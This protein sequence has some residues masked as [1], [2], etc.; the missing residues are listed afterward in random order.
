MSKIGRNDPCSCGSEKKYKKCCMNKS[1]IT[2]PKSTQRHYWDQDEIELMSNDEIIARLK[3]F[4][5]P[6]DEREF[7]KES[8]H[9]KSA[10]DLGE[11]WITGN[12][13]TAVGM[14]EDFI[15]IACIVLWRR[16]LPDRIC[17]EDID[18]LMQ[19]GYAN[20]ND[21]KYHNG[22]KKWKQVWNSLKAHFT[23]EMKDVKDADIILGG[24]QSISSWCQDYEEEL[25]NAIIRDSKFHHDRLILCEE[26][27][28]F[29]PNSDEKILVTMLV[30]KATSLYGIGE[31]EKGETEFQNLIKNHPNNAWGYIGWGDIY[32][33]EMKPPNKKRAIEI[34]SMALDKGLE[35]EEFARQNIH[36]LM[37]ENNGEKNE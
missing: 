23:P 17:M 2:P 5:V 28:Q 7:K 30:G 24:T 27:L 12:P 36:E 15:W 16:L 3:K 25:G 10:S 19:D 20:I 13:I 37:L 6:F 8:Q 29:F 11:K 14:D 31:T 4:G 32:A 18:D 35:D 26:F 21:L 33:F 9:Y 1:S 34:Y 22:C